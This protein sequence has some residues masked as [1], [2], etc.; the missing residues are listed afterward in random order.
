MHLR[1]VPRLPVKQMVFLIIVFFLLPG[2]K[3]EYNSDNVVPGNNV[4]LKISEISKGIK[5]SRY[6]NPVFQIKNLKLEPLPISNEDGSEINWSISNQKFY[7]Y[8]ISEMEDIIAINCKENYTDKSDYID[9]QAFDVFIYFTLNKN[10][11]LLKHENLQIHVNAEIEWISN[12]SKFDDARNFL[13]NEYADALIKDCEISSM[14]IDDIF[15]LK[16]AREEND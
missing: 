13:N 7:D 10:P 15:I 16:I 2:C 1:N 8:E 3:S 11:D 9:Y 6:E 5:K 4:K 14:L 12:V